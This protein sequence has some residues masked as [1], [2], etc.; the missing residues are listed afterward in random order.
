MPLYAI[1]GVTGH[2]GR[3]AVDQLLERGVAPADVVALARTPEKAADL[4]ARGVQVR[5]AD[6][7]RPE[8]LDSALVGVDKLL[9]VSGSE[10]GGRVQQHTNVVEAARKA[11]VS[12][13]LYTSM[14]R[15][16]I[17][18]LVL[19]PEHKGTEEVIAASGLPYTFLRNPWYVENYTGQIATYLAQGTILHA[20]G[21]GRIALATRFELAEAAAAAL[22]EDVEGNVVYEL[23][24]PSYSIG[25]LAAAI[26]EVTGQPVDAKAVTTAEELTAALTGAGLDEGLVGFLVTVDRNIADGDLDNDTDDL[27]RL[28][29]RPVGSLVNAV[30]AARVEAPQT[31]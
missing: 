2:L 5:E 16:G 14:L 17:S 24:G 31:V 9:L 7:D 6:Y 4:A 19:A 22:L 3:L 25:D 18:G 30:R 28:L 27:A 11:G 15:A 29:G 21:E 1:T 20:T 10:V 23:G 8:T 26:T 12:R 13:I